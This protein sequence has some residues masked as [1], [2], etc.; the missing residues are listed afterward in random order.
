ML[1][2][3]TRPVSAQTTQA[4]HSISNEPLASSQELHEPHI[5]MDSVMRGFNQIELSGRAKEM[6]SF[7]AIGALGGAL[8]GAGGL[9]RLIPG[10]ALATA[11]LGLGAALI[12]NSMNPTTRYTPL[13]AP[14]VGMSY[15]GFA[16]VFGYCISETFGVN[17]VIGGAITGAAAG[18]LTAGCKE[19]PGF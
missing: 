5:P 15:G 17:P 12:N 18:F 3:S 4:T 1:I 16:A 7:T 11:G 10:T 8:G 6:L 9:G 19:K 13:I 2:S 14:M